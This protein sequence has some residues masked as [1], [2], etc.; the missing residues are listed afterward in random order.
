M[1]KFVSTFEKQYRDGNYAAQ[2]EF[3][4]KTKS[5]SEVKPLVRK[6]NIDKKGIQLVMDEL[7]KEFKE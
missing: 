5:N 1:G 6:I 7:T 4:K 2:Q 3:L